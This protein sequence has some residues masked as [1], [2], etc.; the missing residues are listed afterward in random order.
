ME[1]QYLYTLKDVVFGLRSIY[2]EYQRELEKLKQYCQENNV[3]D[4]NFYIHQSTKEQPR[5]YCDYITK[6]NKLKR[7]ADYAK[8]LLSGKDLSE[9]SVIYQEGKLNGIVKKSPVSI[10]PD[11]S[12]LFAKQTDK[13]ISSDFIKSIAE[14]HNYIMSLCESGKLYLRTNNIEVLPTESFALPTFFYSPLSDTITLRETDSRFKVNEFGLNRIFEMYFFYNSF[15]P[16]HLT[17]MNFSKIK[18]KK[19]V[20]EPFNPCTQIEF[21]IE[22]TKDVIIL[23]KSKQGC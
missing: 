3:I 18:E 22:E 20:V 14:Y 17:T 10:L 19:F 9:N 6:K 16:Y 11:K 8:E 4:F 1:K 15:T 7:V 2:L 12:L 23:T 5:L 13:I 21:K